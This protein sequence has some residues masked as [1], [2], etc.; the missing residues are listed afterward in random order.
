MDSQT[1]IGIELS[2]E[3]LRY[4]AVERIGDTWRLIRLGSCG[5]DFDVEDA[6]LNHPFEPK[7]A[8]A[9]RNALGD[10]LE[11]V[12]NAELRLALHPNQGHSFFVPVPSSLSDIERARLFLQEARTIVGQD[13]PPLHFVPQPLFIEE[14]PKSDSVIWY[15]INVV[16]KEVYTRFTRYI[17]TVSV[18]TYKFVSLEQSVAKV[19]GELSRRQPLQTSAQAPFIFALGNY[20]NH[21]EYILCRPSNLH[22]S[23]FTET[24]RPEQCAK[25]AVSMMERL[26]FM[27]KLVGQIYLYG[28][29]VDAM[30][31]AS[32]TFAFGVAPQVLNP[33]PLLHVA[34]AS[35]AQQPLSSFVPC[36]GAAL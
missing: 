17:E 11:G 12:R 10:M 26:N 36:I 8:E 9:I 22:F 2:G 31:F 27:P 24:V 30:A 19:I 18:N 4:A 15:Q 28:N 29:A 23:T 3:T 20:D 5:F 6:V 7:A 35:L 1:N 21:S 25:H 16:P 32:M 33:A 13:T 34:E 14:L